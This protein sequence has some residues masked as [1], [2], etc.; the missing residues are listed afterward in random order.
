MPKKPDQAYAARLDID[1]PDRF[2]RLTTFFRPILVIPIAIILSLLSTSLSLATVRKSRS[3]LSS[4]SSASGATAEPREAAG[5]VSPPRAR[6]RRPRRAGLPAQQNVGSG[7]RF[8]YV[9][10]RRETRAP[11][12]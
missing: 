5:T 12:F 1:Y 3:R 10:L 9:P 6:A 7:S 4:N 2:N 11:R 8:G